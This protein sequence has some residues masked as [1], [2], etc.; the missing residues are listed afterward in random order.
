MRLGII[1]GG[2]AA[3]AFGSTWSRI[4][5]PLSGIALRS[6]SEIPRLLDVR[7]RPVAELAA[8]SELILIAVSD[9][10]IDE[11]A[12]SIPKTAAVIFHPSGIKT[13]VRG[14]FSLHPLQSLPPVG[15]PSDLQDSLLVFEGA[16]SEIAEKIAR[17]AGARLAEIAPGQKVLYHAAAVFGSNYIA[18]LLDIA[19]ELIGIDNARDDLAALADSA[20]RNW[21]THTDSRRFTGPAARGDREVLERHLAALA[22]RPQVAEIYRLL[23]ERILASAN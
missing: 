14:G 2:R 11:V 20:I 13:A 6:D 1:G 16:H 7:K 12:A 10:A 17:A 4:G 8:D 21:R 5:W 15:E 3:W 22:D 19:Q 18:A 23:A 9:R